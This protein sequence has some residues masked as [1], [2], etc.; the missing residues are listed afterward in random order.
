M[1]E[2]KESKSIKHFLVSVIKSIFRI[3]G[4]VFCIIWMDSTI[5]VA[6]LATSFL[7]AEILGIVEEL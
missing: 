5:A 3:I 6:A 4:C 7:L 2:E 1:P